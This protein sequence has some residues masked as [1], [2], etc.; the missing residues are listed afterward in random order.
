MVQYITYVGWAAA[1]SSYGSQLISITDA[2]AV[3][4]RA[5]MELL[6]AEQHVFV[7]LVNRF[8]L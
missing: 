7:S 6:P 5:V 3:E 4:A 1:G 8:H 2:A